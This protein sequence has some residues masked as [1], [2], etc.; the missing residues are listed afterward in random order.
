MATLKS[1][2]GKT[3]AQIRAMSDIEVDAL[4]YKLE[5]NNQHTAVV[6]VLAAHNNDGRILKA[7]EAF[8]EMHQA[9]GYLTS[10]AIA[11]RES[12]RNQIKAA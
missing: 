2:T 8:D 4:R 11:L 7:L 12:F 5:D 1:I 6:M 3:A 10:E 9:L